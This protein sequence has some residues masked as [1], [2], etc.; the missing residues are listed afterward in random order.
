MRRRTREAT[1]RPGESTLDELLTV[2][3]APAELLSDPDGQVR[4]VGAQGLYV[5][6]TR[7]CSRLEIGVDGVALHALESGLDGARHAWF[8][9]DLRGG[10]TTVRV[11]RDRTLADRHAVEHVELHNTGSASIGLRFELRARSDLAATPV[12]KSGAAV[13]PVVPQFGPEGV[14][15]ARE[16]LAATLHAEPAAAETVRE[17]ADAV[18]TWPVHLEPG[19]RWSVRLTLE[20][21]PPGP[22]EFHPAEPIRWQVPDVDAGRWGDLLERSLADLG[23]LLLADPHAPGDRFAAA[24]SPW[25]C[26]LF[27]RDSL[28]T[29]R[30]LLPLSTELAAGTLRVLARRQ[31]THDDPWSE[32]EPGKILH[33]FRPGGL[34]AGGLDLPPRYY[35]TIDATALWCCLLHDAWRTGM[36]TDEVGAL[37][38]NLEA[39]LGWI[40]RTAG[41]EG[42]LTYRGSSG[43][44]LANQGWKDSAG[45]VRWADG[46]IAERPLAL[47][48]VQGYAYAAARGGA[49]LLAAFGRPGADRWRDWADR[50]AER[51]RAAFWIDDPDGRYPA[52]ALDGQDRPV[53]GP[54]S[55]MGHLL[56]TGILDDAEA[57]LVA[58]RLGRPDLDGGRGLRT[59]S[60][61]S[62]GYDPLSYHCGSIWP[63]D[64]AIAVLGLAGIGRDDVA[65]SLGEGLVTVAG[66]FADRLPELYAE[67]DGET[68]SYPTACRPQAWAAAGAV[69]VV[70]YLSNGTVPAWTRPE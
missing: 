33:E 43:G 66:E 28:W 65:K 52:I 47:C 10:S 14:R 35:G 1:D 9:G 7:F 26:T 59:L 68:V 63:H 8:V 67:L 42:F 34:R 17:G 21:S 18:L 23:G 61:S 38:P 31:G 39:A 64:T 20:P 46:T 55:N 30:M 6:D 13:D 62:A 48:E 32:E 24:G 27:G 12:V 22:E 70:T 51:F 50:L 49:E 57:Q 36:A 11:H 41:P 54:A 60:S 5:G 4:A 25:F 29:A 53:T 37:L 16:R 58:D 44:G 56:S 2:L 40:E 45:A 15:W 19:A 3:A 69:A